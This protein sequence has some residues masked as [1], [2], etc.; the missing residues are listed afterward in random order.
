MSTEYTGPA[1]QYEF[2]ETQNQSIGTLARRMGMVGFVMMVFGLLQ[3]INGVSAMIISRNPGRMLETA[4]KAGLT[5]DQLELLK[6][7][8]S[9][10]FW[11]SPL[12]VSA[13]A[14][15]MSGLL[16]VLMGSWTQMAAGS[17]ARIV[18]T[19]G[20]DIAR[21]MDGLGALNLMYGM[22]YYMLLVAALLTV[23]SLVTSLVQSWRGG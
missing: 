4:E 2:D 8:S 19:K 15:A 3:L 20:Q 14:F 12:T 10:G 13:I 21:L 18:K 1:G 6:Q 11:S 5:P 7:A 17:F 16:L 22:I 9:G 23:A